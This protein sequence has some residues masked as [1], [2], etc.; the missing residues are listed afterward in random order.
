VVGQYSRVQYSLSRIYC[1]G[2]PIACRIEALDRDVVAPVL[3]SLP[4][5]RRGEHEAVTLT[6]LAGSRE[7]VD[8]KR[9]ATMLNRRSANWTRRLGQ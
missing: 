6:G 3:S 8:R 2:R 9:A 4:G 1:A 5:S 7:I